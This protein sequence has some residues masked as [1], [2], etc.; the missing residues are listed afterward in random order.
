LVGVRREDDGKEKRTW[1]PEGTRYAPFYFLFVF[2]DD[3][4]MNHLN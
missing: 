1:D 4:V 2:Q 3:F